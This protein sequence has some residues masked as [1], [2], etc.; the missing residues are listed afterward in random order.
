MKK[1]CNKKLSKSVFHYTIL[2]NKGYGI[3]LVIVLWLKSIVKATQNIVIVINYIYSI[4]NFQFFKILSIR[5]C[6]INVG[7]CIFAAL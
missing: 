3:I 4:S 5:T 7:I 2:Q 6:Q 1:I